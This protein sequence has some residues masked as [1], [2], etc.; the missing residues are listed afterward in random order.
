MTTE[1]INLSLQQENIKNFHTDSFGKFIAITS[2]NNLIG[3]DFRIELKQEFSS[4]I[5]R[6]LN[7][8]KL[9]II[10]DTE[11]HKN[12]GFIIDFDGKILKKFN[13]GIRIQDVIVNKNKI[14]ISY[15]DEGILGKDGPNNEG[16]TVFSFEGEQKFGY[17]SSSNNNDFIDCYCLTNYGVNKIIFY[18]YSDFQIHELDLETNKITTYETP[19]DFL[20][21]NS[22]SVLQHKLIF[23][24][25]YNNKTTF[26]VWDLKTKTIERVE[27][28]EKNLLATD[29]GT[30]F[31]YDKKHFTL[32]RPIS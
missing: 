4:P 15:F 30:F 8:K 14:I 17:K 31:K 27:S 12:N 16:V 5:V 3:N 6:F 24:S 10:D 29:N 13:A 32:I 2:Q 7:D 20:G 18:G 1:R 22:L 11:K 26:F 28:N 23:H 9:L 21:S 19:I 25:S